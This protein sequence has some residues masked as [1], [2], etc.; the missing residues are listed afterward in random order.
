MTPPEARLLS[1][2]FGLLMAALPLTHAS[3]VAAGVG[4]AA[5]VAVLA[6]III[7]PAAVLAVSLTVAVIALAGIA[8]TLAAACGLCATAYLVLRHT[9]AVTAPTAVAAVGFTVVG[10]VGTAFPLRSP[11][12]PLVAPPAV[13]GCFLLATGPFL[14]SRD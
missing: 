13:L 4:A 10:L 3:P 6:G 11:W 2:G 8:P 12:L 5:V 7:R 14:A 9:T 1:A